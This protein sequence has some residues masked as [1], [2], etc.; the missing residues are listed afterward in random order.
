MRHLAAAALR[1]LRFADTVLLAA[2]LAFVLR[3]SPPLSPTQTFVV[4]LV[5]PCYA[6]LLNTFGVYESNRTE[7]FRGMLRK[8][9]SAQVA[10]GFILYNILFV[11]FG[12]RGINL[13]LRFAICS[14][15][16]LA[17][18]KTLLYLLLPLIRKRGFDR[19][20]VCFV[21]TWEEAAAQERKF[22]EHPEWGLRIGCVGIG[23][24]D[25]RVYHRFEDGAP[26]AS[27]FEELLL[28]EVI[29]EV[30]VVATP[31]NVPA[32]RFMLT[33]CAKYGLTGRVR[34]S[35]GDVVEV[36]R[37]QGYLG[38]VTIAVNN[39]LDRPA[40]RFG[41]RAMDLILAGVM[42]FFAIPVLAVIAILVRL[43]SPGP[44]LF[45]QERVGQNGRRFRLIKFRT[46]IEKAESELHSIY[47]TSITEG[48]AFKNPNDWRVTHVGRY[49]RRF[50][51]DE[52]P[53]LWNVLRGDMSLVGPRPLPVTEAA[54]VTGEDRRRFSVPP[55]LTCLW[56]VSGRSD[57]RF[58][59]WMRLDLQYIDS[60]SLWLDAK[61]LLLTVP[62]V[63]SG[64]GAY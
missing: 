50:S 60:W 29:D 43:S 37:V 14:T 47:H 38:D 61:L 42:L 32:E 33:L 18:Q 53:Q 23:P 20:K 5:I 30:L 56:Q 22:N 4:L 36:G 27:S 25:A 44:I 58:A 39:K 28:I 3:T 40:T 13:T 64:R 11:A 54:R 34:I 17:G 57:V 9:V 62:A 10:G 7:G 2:C 45:Q 19:R 52:L 12:L 8:I 21:G 26:L 63:I 24:P 49:L 31:Q 48:P 6:F 46:M 15:L 1:F 35:T 41:K 55:G 16:V 51:L 59:D